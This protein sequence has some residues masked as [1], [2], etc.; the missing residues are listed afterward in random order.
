[1]LT[2]LNQV[3]YGLGWLFIFGIALGLAVSALYFAVLLI[4]A[5]LDR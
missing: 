3:A 5:W 1:M 4:A 2:I